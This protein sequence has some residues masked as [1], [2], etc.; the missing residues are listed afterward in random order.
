MASFYVLATGDPAEFLAI[1]IAFHPT[2]AAAT[3]SARRV[4]L[5]RHDPLSASHDHIQTLVPN[6]ISV[7]IRAAIRLSRKR[8]TLSAADGIA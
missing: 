3:I 5:R 7:W 4:L 6:R 8:R 2:T 1:R